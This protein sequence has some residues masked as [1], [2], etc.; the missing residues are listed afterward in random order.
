M[1]NLVFGSGMF[2][3]AL[4]MIGIWGEPE[5]VPSHLRVGDAPALA[6]LLEQRGDPLC[7]YIYTYTYI[8]F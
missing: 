2:K 1:V 4:L 5:V 7:V 3:I 8:R 6:L